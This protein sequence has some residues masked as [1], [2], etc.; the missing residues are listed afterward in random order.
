MKY[1]NILIFVL[2]I[3]ALMSGI[4]TFAALQPIPFGVQPNISGNV[5]FD[6]ASN[7]TE[8]ESNAFLKDNMSQNSNEKETALIKTSF[9]AN[10]N[11]L[12]LIFFLA[13]LLVIL[14]FALLKIRKIIN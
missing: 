9:S 8:H 1:L 11:L 7:K 10:K 2:I 3:G 13:V 6:N 14:I 4:N 12:H 5:N